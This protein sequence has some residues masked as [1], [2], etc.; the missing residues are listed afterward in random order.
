MFRSSYSVWLFF[1][2]KQETRNERKRFNPDFTE[3]V[4]WHIHCKYHLAA[5]EYQDL[6]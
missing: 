5:A 4:L 3:R 6:F 2:Y 1:I